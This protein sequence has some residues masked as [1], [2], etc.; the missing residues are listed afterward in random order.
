MLIVGLI[1]ATAAL[2]A[3]PAPRAIYTVRVAP[4]ATEI[5]KYAASQLQL[6]LGLSSD[7]TTTTATS[8]RQLAVGYGASRAIGVSAGALDGLG[9]EGYVIAS[10]PS[11]SVAVSGGVSSRRGT[12]YGAFGLLR[13]LG[14][15]FFAPTE[16]LVPSAS[17][18]AAAAA[19]GIHNETRQPGLIWRSIESFETNGAAP[20]KV[21]PTGTAEQKAANYR[22][23]VRA[24]NNGMA[25]EHSGGS[26]PTWAGASAHSS[27]TLLGAPDSA[28]A[29]PAALYASHQDWFWPRDLQQCSGAGLRNFAWVVGRRL[30]VYPVL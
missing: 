29:P 20:L 27:Y 25:T 26:F 1:A 3:H 8:P 13:R 18:I 19:A 12:L 30:M 22:W 14:F 11:G 7:F 16:T 23:M 24:H 17:T 2:M 6:L 5:E 28:R 4:S 9:D 10:T 21:P 15:R